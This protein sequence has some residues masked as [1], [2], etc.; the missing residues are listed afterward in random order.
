METEVSEQWIEKQVKRDEVGAVR[1]D[2]SYNF[3]SLM[4]RYHESLDM[5]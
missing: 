4:Y 3:F 2:N 1:E 5:S